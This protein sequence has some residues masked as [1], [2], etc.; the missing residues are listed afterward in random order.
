RCSSAPCPRVRHFTPR[1]E[2][3]RQ[4][5]NIPALP[6]AQTPARILDG[7]SSPWC[8]SESS[9][10][11]RS[12]VRHPN[13]C[14]LAHCI[15][16]TDHLGL[17]EEPRGARRGGSGQG[18][19]QKP[20][21]PWPEKHRRVVRLQR[22]ASVTLEPVYAGE[23]GHGLDTGGDRHDTWSADHLVRVCEIQKVV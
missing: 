22:I 20:A 18:A 3:A 4:A 14:R 6:T 8:P 13:A 10:L 16:A 11:R 1:E 2:D 21:K 19:W 12:H 15:H 23:R 17:A 5:R 9:L 7:A